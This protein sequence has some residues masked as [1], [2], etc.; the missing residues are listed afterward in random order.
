MTR[1]RWPG[2]VLVLASPASAAGWGCGDDLPSVGAGSSA[3]TGLASSSSSS[4]DGSSETGGH[5]PAIVD[6]GQDVLLL[7]EDAAVV[8]T[9][10]VLDPDG[11]VIAGELFGPG[12]PAKYA[13][14]TP[15]PSDRWAASV[16][17]GDV[18]SR[19]SLQFE[20]ELELPFRVRMEDATG[21]VAEA[22]IT[23]RAACGGIGGTACGGTCID[24]QVDPLHCGGCDRPCEVKEPIAGVM[25]NGGCAGGLC[26]PWWG[27]CF[28]PAP[29]VTCAGQCAAEGARCVAQGCDGATVMS[30]DVEGRCERAEAGLM[31]LGS[32]DADLGETAD[33]G[34]AARCCCE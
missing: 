13:D 26:R 14:L 7:R 23:V 2:L 20:G 5:P 17:W 34:V 21:L 32:C 15:H 28:A 22:S 11:D 3:G 6:I 25:T 4:S 31:R 30:H 8:L 33:F 1:S 9:A 10:V 16:S 24:P 27:P 19:G 18:A 29:A 12:E